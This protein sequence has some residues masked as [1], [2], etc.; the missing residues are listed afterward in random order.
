MCK[1]CS[2]ASPWQS[3][4]KANVFI[5]Q[6]GILFH[7]SEIWRILSV[8]NGSA[9]VFSGVS[10]NVQDLAPSSAGAIYGQP[11]FI[12][13][14]CAD[15]SLGFLRFNLGFL[16]VST[17]FMNTVGAL[18]GMFPTCLLSSFY[19]IKCT[20]SKIDLKWSVSLICGAGVLVVSLSGYLIEVTQTW[21]NVFAVITLINSTGLGVF[22][23]FGDAQR[24]DLEVSSR[25]Q[26]I[27]AGSP[28]KPDTWKPQNTTACSAEKTCRKD[29]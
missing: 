4:W 13:H 17:G 1:C 10:V 27:W 8:S 21:S 25:V 12:L 14:S 22:L 18:L 26:V 28:R 3:W 20:D 5:Y 16:S 29:A 11:H 19:L 6:R 24:V 23:I 2:S 9:G 15:V 7:R